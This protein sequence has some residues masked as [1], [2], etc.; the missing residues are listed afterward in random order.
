MRKLLFIISVLVI[1]YIFNIPASASEVPATNIAG[2][3]QQEKGYDVQSV[4]DNSNATES[5]LLRGILICLK[6]ID[7]YV[8][9]FVTI[10]FA[11]GL[12]YFVILKP[13]RYFLI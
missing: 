4:I 3:E 1:M 12:I 9:F 5:E 10:V 7:V 2:T 8:Q 6:D 13:L 11:I